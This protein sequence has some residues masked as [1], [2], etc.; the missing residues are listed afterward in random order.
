M[1][2]AI[3]CDEPQDSTPSF[4]FYQI[5]GLS[6]LFCSLIFIFLFNRLK[7][8]YQNNFNN[9]FKCI[10]RSLFKMLTTLINL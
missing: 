2:K 3:T 1:P 10:N 7:V 9:G 8:S 4:D 5:Y 6:V